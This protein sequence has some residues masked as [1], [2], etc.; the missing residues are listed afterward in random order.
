MKQNTIQAV[1]QPD[2]APSSSLGTI[3]R[4]RRPAL[5]TMVADQ[6][7]NA[8]VFGELTL[9]EAVSEDRLATALGVSRTPVR[10]ALSALQ[11]QGLVVIEPQRGS[12][13]F[14]PTQQDV[15]ELCACRAMFETSALKLAFEHDRDGMLQM[16]RAAETELEAAEDKGDWRGSAKADEAFHEAIFAHC[17]NRYLVKSYSLISG[18]VGAMRYFAR[19]LQRN[20]S[21]TMK[22]HHTIIKAIAKGDVATAL[23]VL[24]GHILDM[25]GR[26][27]EAELS[28]KE[29]EKAA[30]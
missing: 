21:A 19:G 1:A 2:K 26:F 27:R 30:S 23:S 14:Q 10:E 4:E 29:T 13:V 11:L 12:F 5:A 7:R 15:E 18:P 25:A 17:G 8:I 6:I 16:L 28:Q 24:S 9:G 22:E 3:V 20:R